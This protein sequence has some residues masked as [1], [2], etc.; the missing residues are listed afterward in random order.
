MLHNCSHFRKDSIFAL[1][2]RF[3]PKQANC[4]RGIF[5]SWA[6]PRLVTGAIECGLLSVL[7]LEP[8]VAQVAEKISV[9]VLGSDK[10]MNID[11]C[12][13][14]DLC[15]WTWNKTAQ[16]S[17]MFFLFNSQEPC[18]WG[19]G[20]WGVRGFLVAQIFLS[21]TSANDFVILAIDPGN[22]GVI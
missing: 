13:G 10:L 7:E 19:F 15:F 8:K 5:C 2:L 18:E 6:V 20:Q 21:E 14:C 17:D 11:K 16:I 12:N 3:H 22:W 9:I 1:I 4:R